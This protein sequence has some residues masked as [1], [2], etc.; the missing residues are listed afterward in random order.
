MHRPKWMN[1]AQWEHFV[2]RWAGQDGRVRCIGLDC[3]GSD[4]ARITVDHTIPRSA[5]GTDD[6]SNLQP[7]CDLCNSRKGNRPDG[8]WRRTLYFDKPLVTSRLRISQLD[9][10]YNRI[11]EFDEFFAR[12]YSAINGK[13]FCFLQVVGAGKTLGMFCLPFA[14][15][16]CAAMHWPAAPR[17]DR[18]LIVT[19][20]Q[21]LRAQIASELRH[22]PLA[23]GLVNEPPRVL[24]ITS[25]DMLVDSGLDYDI[26]VMCPNML[27]PQADATA[28]GS[29]PLLLTWSPGI[30]RVLNRH[31]LIAFDEMHYA[32]RG[33][34]LLLDAAH[35]S[36]VFGFTASPID[37]WGELLADMIKMSVYTYHDAVINDGSMKYLG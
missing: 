8:Y 5:Q 28:S 6:L 7:L 33:V 26:A 16:D 1:P 22:E 13:L 2:G 25:G 17:V 4:D 20:D 31:P 21:A 24:E 37:A 32:H 35:H 18:M 19:K 14:L 30:E 9:Y 10:I 29:Q 3:R 12:P 36:L 11:R 23:F 27:W 34:R 15:N